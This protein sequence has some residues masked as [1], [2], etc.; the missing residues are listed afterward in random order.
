MTEPVA[1]EVGLV[2]YGIGPTT[3]DLVTDQIGGSLGS[4]S[5]DL[6][7][8][9]VATVNEFVRGLPCADQV[10]G[11]VDGA[12]WPARL[13]LGAT[14]L[15]ARLLRRRNSPDGISALG[16]QGVV[17]VSRNDPDVA[18]LL[19]LGTHRKPALA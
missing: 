1:E 5:S 15:A 6:A 17:Y 2:P 12:A 13:T 10:D 8:L 3:L 18:Q 7:D 9:H 14:L 16:D 11:D 19:N 4:I